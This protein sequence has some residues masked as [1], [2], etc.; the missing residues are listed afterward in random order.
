[1]KRST[2][3][4]YLTTA[5]ATV[6]V[7][8]FYFQEEDGIRDKLVTG[9]QTCALPILP[10]VWMKRHPTG[11]PRCAEIAGSLPAV[12][13]GRDLPGPVSPVGWCFIHS[14]G[15][16]A[17]GTTR[18]DRYGGRSY[19]RNAFRTSAPGSSLQGRTGAIRRRGAGISAH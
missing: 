19:R 17:I 9:V 15:K 11:A 18:V 5:L 10:G 4:R 14:P 12:Y 16:L 6:C 3:S 8:R 2:R 1:M 7:P 13:H